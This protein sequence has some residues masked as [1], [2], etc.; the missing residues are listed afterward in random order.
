MAYW[1]PILILIDGRHAF[2]RKAGGSVA[3]VKFPDVPGSP[4]GMRGNWRIADVQ[5]VV[6][7]AMSATR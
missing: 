2:T 4:P 3:F 6:L 5:A 7:A 1:I